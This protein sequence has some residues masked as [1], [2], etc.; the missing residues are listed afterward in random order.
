MPRAAGREPADGSARRETTASRSR[1]GWR[2]STPRPPSCAAH[3]RAAWRRCVRPTPNEELYLLRAWRDAAPPRAA[4]PGRRPTRGDD[5]VEGRQES[6][7]AR[8]PC[9][10]LDPSDAIERPLATLE[11]GKVKVPLPTELISSRPMAGACAG[12]S[13]RSRASWCSTRTAAR[14]RSTPRWCRRRRVHRDRWHVHQP[15]GARTAAR[16]GGFPARPAGWQVLRSCSGIED[17]SN[18]RA[19]SVRSPRW[20]PRFRRSQARL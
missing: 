14:R 9:E 3:P 2:R 19:P 15:C 7:H 17:G 4:C 1:S 18:C 13:S 11:S 6:Q 12:R 16:G 8:A 20:R 5:F 10:G